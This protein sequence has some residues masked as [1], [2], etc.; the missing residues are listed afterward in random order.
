VDLDYWTSD[1]RKGTPGEGSMLAAK[2]N[3]LP[4]RDRI[5]F[6]SDGKEVIP[7]VQ[8]IHTPGHTVGHTCFV[9]NSGGKTLYFAGDLVHHN[10]IVEKPRMEDAFDTDRP[11]GIQTRLKQMDMLAAQRMLSLVYHLPWPGLGH[12]VKHGDGFHFEPEPMS[13]T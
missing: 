1:A 8:A 7:G 9:I 2:K 5:L 3:L 10:I 12:F 13:F 11:L 6:Y 4:N